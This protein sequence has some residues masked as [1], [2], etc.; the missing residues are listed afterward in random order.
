MAGYAPRHWEDYNFGTSDNPVT[1]PARISIRKANRLEQEIQDL[2][3]KYYNS[4]K[5]VDIDRTNN[6]RVNLA[7]KLGP[8][9]QRSRTLYY[10]K[11]E[12]GE[13]GTFMISYPAEMPDLIKALS[14]DEKI[15]IKIASEYTGIEAQEISQMI[16][17]NLIKGTR[18]TVNLED[19]NRIKN[20]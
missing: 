8:V 10:R 12:T 13:D 2:S 3:T 18:A 5:T 14:G 16:R 17:E 19:I 1:K 4:D 7:V 15:S 20:S 6:H 11:T 9:I